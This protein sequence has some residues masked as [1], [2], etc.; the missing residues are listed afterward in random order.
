M[1]WEVGARSNASAAWDEAEEALRVGS[2]DNRLSRQGHYHGPGGLNG[3]VRNGNGWDPAGLVAGMRPKGGE[4]LRT[5]MIR[6]IETHA[7]SI[8][9]SFQLHLL[10]RVRPFPHLFGRGPCGCVG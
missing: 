4:T 3:R 7:D 8:A 2:G 10:V 5:R 6:E 1:G 9:W